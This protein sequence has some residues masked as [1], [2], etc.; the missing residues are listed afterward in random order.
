MLTET[1]KPTVLLVED[2]EDDAFL[3]HWRFQQSGCECS[4]H[5]VLDGAAA[6]EFLSQASRSDS[7]PQFIFLDLKM[8]I[9]N[10]FEVLSWLKEQTFSSAIPVVVLSGSDQQNDKE[11]ALQ[12]GALDYLVKP[13]KVSDIE[14]Y[15]GHLCPPANGSG[16]KLMKAGS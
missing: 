15:L 14:R 8:P 9:L 10:G 3:F 4:V 13:L 7:L 11:Q 2:S 12:L 1:K 5:H 6:V 16:Q